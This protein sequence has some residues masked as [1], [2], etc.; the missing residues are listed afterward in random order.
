MSQKILIAGAGF[1]GV[2]GAL[3]AARV[4]DRAG[5]TASDVDI[6]LISPKP[7]LQIRPRMYESEPHV[8]VAPLLP[9]L[10]AVGV[11]YVERAALTKSQFA[12]RPC[13]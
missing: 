1:A 5:V 11:N 13:G 6:T 7:E 9:L 12:T 8:M 3:G 2:W 4:L 10:D